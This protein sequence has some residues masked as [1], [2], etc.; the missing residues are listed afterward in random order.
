MDSLISQGIGTAICIVVFI[1]AFYTNLWNAQN[2]PLLSQVLFPETSN[3]TNHV[4][5]NQTAVIGP[6]N[7][8]DQAALATEGLPWFT[9]SYAISLLT[10][11]MC[12]TAAITYL[13]L[14]FWPEMKE[15]CAFLSFTSLKCLLYPQTWDL[16]FWK[17]GDRP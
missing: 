7:I 14:F 10:G 11:S 2:F 17:S 9:T 4:Q 12:F 5:W 6:D 15:A 1:A 16:K 8:I 3:S 13:F